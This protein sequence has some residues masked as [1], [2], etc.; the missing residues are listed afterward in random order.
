MEGSRSRGGGESGG[1]AN[2]TS[3]SRSA[4]DRDGRDGKAA[5]SHEDE[6]GGFGDRSDR[7]SPIVDHVVVILL[8]D[9]SVAVGIS[10][11]FVDDV[12]ASEALPDAKHIPCVN[13]TIVIDV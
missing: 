4:A 3:P 10:E 7:R 13:D 2:R 11:K 1:L 5:E 8:V 12:A 9:H 6:R